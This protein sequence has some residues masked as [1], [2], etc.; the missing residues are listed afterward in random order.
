MPSHKWVVDSQHPQGHLVELTAEEET[1]LEVDR[2]AWLEQ[3]VVE[4]AEFANAETMRDAVVTRL[5]TLVAAADKIAAGEATPAEQRD[6]LAL[7]LRSTA[8][9]AR[10]VL[11]KLD[12]AA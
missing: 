3:D 9:L 1:Q 12:A 11:R 4:D 7:N 2:Q 8:R 6:A 10:I 5:D